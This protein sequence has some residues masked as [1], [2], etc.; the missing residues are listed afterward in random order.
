MVVKNA[1]SGRDPNYVKKIHMKNIVSRTRSSHTAPRSISHIF[2][3]V[4][5][6]LKMALDY[7]AFRGEMIRAKQEFKDEEIQKKS[8][9]MAKWLR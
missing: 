1:A 2:A 7:R 4:N 9:I 6:L 8:I 5:F 3:L